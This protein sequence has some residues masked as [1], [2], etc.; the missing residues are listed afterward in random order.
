MNR[1]LAI[2]FVFGACGGGSGNS[3]A[4]AGADAHVFL[5][6][7]PVVPQM[8]TI[9]GMSTEDGQSSSTPLAGVAI[10]VV[11]QSDET[12][13]LATATTDAQG[14]YS[15]MVPTGGGVVDA[16]IVATKSGY[17]DNYVYPAAPFQTDT[18][19][20]NANLITSSNFNLLGIFTGQQ[21]G[22]GLIVIEILDAN[23]MPVMG[24]TVTS[25]PASTYR[26]SDSNGTPTS[27][28]ATAAD[29]TAFLINVP[30]GHVDVSATKAGMVLKT[31]GIAAHA[32]KFT[33]TVITP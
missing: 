26:Y 30:P 20:A 25:T 33:T 1:A 14:K 18:L 15:V 13:P 16:Y 11:K 12:T 9:A 6:A 22:K 4:D 8:I 17:A 10:S 3:N 32:D 21:T 28:T 5:D 27:T 19:M 7:P 24:A 23:M 29:G 31:H 2:A